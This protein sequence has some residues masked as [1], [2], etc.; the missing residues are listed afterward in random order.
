M[1]GENANPSHR[2]IHGPV[3]G[4]D[5]SRSLYTLFDNSFDKRHLVQCSVLFTPSESPVRIGRGVLGSG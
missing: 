3:K 4:M 2:E 1:Q 5:A